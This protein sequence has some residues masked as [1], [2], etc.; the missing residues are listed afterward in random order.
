MNWL[1]AIANDLLNGFSAGDVPV[2][3]AR[4]FAAALIALLLKIIFKIK[5]KEGG[6]II[7]YIVPLAMVIAIV[8]PI[9][10]FSISLGLIVAAIIVG[11]FINLKP[12]S[13]AE[14][15]YSSIGLISASALGAG[16]VVYTLAGM[17]LVF[18]YLIISKH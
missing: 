12:K 8:T 15:I 17:V 11:M 4:I 7:G 14:L 5:H 16:Y 6:L 3:V 18:V 9:T 13:N 2:F 10:Q 1:K